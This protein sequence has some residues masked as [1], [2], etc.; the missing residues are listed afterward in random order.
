MKRFIILLAICCLPAIWIGAQETAYHP[1]LKEGKVWECR[2][3][4][5]RG[6]NEIRGDYAYRI[7]GDTLID[8]NSY[9]KV[10][11]W[12]SFMYED[13]EWHYYG[14]ARED[15]Q[16]VF[17]LPKGYNDEFK[18]YDF[19]ISPND[20]INYFHHYAVNADFHILI[21]YIHSRILNDGISRK[22]MEW[23]INWHGSP[24]VS[25]NHFYWIE[26]IGDVIDP[27]NVQWWVIQMGG[28]QACY[29]DGVCIYGTS[30]VLNIQTSQ[31]VNGKS[32]NRKCY[33]LT[34]R[35]LATPPAK[36]VYIE[37]GKKWVTK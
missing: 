12:D 15:G 33:D 23:M 1:L 17:F 8:E 28:V 36:G 10:F 34:G 30:G 24:G 26:S 2:N 25:N 32:V 11:L 6:D 13:S 19:S 5:Q 20:T 35:R 3:L 31:I 21:R 29:E 7:R 14:A 18:L 9:K 16:R 22:E 27:W 4:R 37:N